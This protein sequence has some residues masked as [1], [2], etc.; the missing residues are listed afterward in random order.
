MRKGII[1]WGILVTLMFVL[2]GCKKGGQDENKD[3][4]EEVIVGFSMGTLMEDRWVRDRDIFLAKAK[5]EDIKVIVNIE[6]F[7]KHKHSSNLIACKVWWSRSVSTSIS[8]TSSG[9]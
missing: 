5:Q 2:G 6:T 8:S 9:V 1:L 7:Q 4:K 3:P